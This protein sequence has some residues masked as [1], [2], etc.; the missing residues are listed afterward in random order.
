MR[1]SCNELIELNLVVSG[2][3]IHSAPH[4]PPHPNPLLDPLLDIHYKAFFPHDMRQLTETV[5]LS[6][7]LLR[8]R[9]PLAQGTMRRCMP[10]S[11][12][13]NHIVASRPA[14]MNVLNRGYRRS[15]HSIGAADFRKPTMA[16]TLAGDEL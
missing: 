7:Y 13:W 14:V 12:M 4:S 3:A 15:G 16:L 9:R 5:K 6:W 11:S 8:V 2:T 1:S 10:A